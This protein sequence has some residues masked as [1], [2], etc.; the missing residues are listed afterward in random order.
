MRN[1]RVVGTSLLLCLLF[2]GC[3][4]LTPPPVRLTSWDDAGFRRLTLGLCEDYPEESRTIGAAGMDL[5]LARELGVPVLRVAFGWDSIEA[6]PGRYDWSFWDEF[7]DLAETHEVRLVPYVCYAPRWAV[8][9][10]DD[11]FWRRPPRDPKT[12]GNF[13]RV[14]SARYRKQIQSWELWNEPDNPAYWLGSAGEFAELLV[15]G[16][17]G[18]REGNPGAQVVFGGIAWNL[19]FVDDVLTNSL[20]NGAFDVLNLHNYNE[21]WSDEPMEN[22]PV[23]TGRARDLLDEHSLTN[24][25][26]WLAEVGY[27]SFRRGRFVSDQYSAVFPHEHSPE[28]QAASLVRAL[29]LAAASESVGIAAWYRINDLPPSQEVIGDVNN[30]HLGLLT[31]D[32]R[33][34]PAMAALRFLADQ[35]DEPYRSIDHRLTVRRTAATQVEIHGFEFAEGR[36]LVAA[37]LRNVVPGQRRRALA[38][39]IDNRRETIEFR[40]PAARPGVGTIHGWDGMSSGRVVPDKAGW[41]RVEIAGPRLLLITLP[42]TR[43][44]TN[45]P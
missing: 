43:S 20:P 22:L 24:V 5:R 19:S 40:S 35:F 42:P 1:L 38:E 39:G 11:D 15:E 28:H 3:A 30:R 13:M 33:P 6:Q 18:V 36:T 25:G 45:L 27:S 29:I 16:S 23:F 31:A 2:S 34:K 4:D 37:W 17:R 8:S 10:P 12:F 9:D 44:P 41:Y 26:I 32:R 7:V 14:I 21:T